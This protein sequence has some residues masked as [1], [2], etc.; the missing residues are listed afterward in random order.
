MIKF[1]LGVIIGAGA[2]AFISNPAGKAVLAAIVYNLEAT[3]GTV[4]TAALPV[5]SEDTAAPPMS[6]ATVPSAAE[7]VPVP[8]A[9][10]AGE[11]ESES[12]SY[13]ALDVYN[14]DNEAPAGESGL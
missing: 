11:A 6:G 1:I 10:A 4:T 3:Q 9:P 5:L 7:E 12:T 13:S 14:K 8:V 2:W